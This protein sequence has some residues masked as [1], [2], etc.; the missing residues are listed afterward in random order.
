MS[1]VTVNRWE[2]GRT[3][4]SGLALERLQAL[5]ESVREVVPERSTLQ[6]DFLGNPRAVRLLVE[7]ERLS[8]GHLANPAFAIETSLVDPL[9]HQRIAVYEHMLPHER[10]RFLLADDAGAG[11]TIMAGLYIREMLSRRLV[12]R[13]LVVPPAGL[14]GNWAR[15]LQRFFG[16]E[17][18]LARSS[19]LRQGNPFTRNGSDLTVCSLDTLR[20]EAMFARLQAPDVEPYDLVVF[21]EAHKL[22]ARREPDLTT[23]KTDRYKLAEALAGI[24]HDDPRWSL[25]WG[26]RHLLLLTATPHMG[27]DYPYYALWRLLEPET[28]GAFEAFADYGASERRAHF[29]RRTKEEMVDISGA[30]LYRPRYS[31]TLGFDLSQGKDSEQELYDRTTAYMR[32]FY[33]KAGILNAS[34][35]RLAQSV[36]QRRL[37]SSTYAVVRSLERRGQ[38]LDELIAQVREGRLTEHQI[39]SALQNISDPFAGTADDDADEA[40]REAHEEIEDRLL[41]LLLS[42]SLQDL[43]LERREVSGLVTLGHGVLAAAQDSKFT[44]LRRVLLDE[45]YRDQ[46]FIVFTEHRDTL[47]W[48]R[49]QLEAL[50]FTDRIA[51]IHGGL[52]FRQREAE[53]ERFRLPSSQGGAQYLLATDAAG[54]GINLQF[55]WLMVNYDIPW[56]PARLEQRMGRIHRYGQKHDVFIFNLVATSTREGQVL[57]TLLHKLEDIRLAM[58]SDKVFDVIGHVLDGVSMLDFMAEALTAEGAV[59]AAERLGGLLTQ[60][61]VNALVVAR[62]SIYGA[63]GDVARE[64]PRLRAITE[65]EALLRLLPGYVRQFVLNA[66]EE[67]DLHVVGDPD[68]FFTLSPG[69]P[70]VAD[71]LWDALEHYPPEARGRLTVY[72]PPVTEPAVFLHPGEPLFE[73]LREIVLARCAEAATQGAVFEDPTATEASMVFAIDAAVL[74]RPAAAGR[75][76][77]TVESVLRLVRVTADGRVEQCALEHLLLLTPASHFPSEHAALALRAAELQVRALGFIE[78]KVLAASVGERR[79]A[80]LEALPERERALVRGFDFQAAELAAMR[81][82]L[83]ERVAEGQIAHKSQLERVK[84]RQRMLEQRKLLALESTR[85]EPDR[86][87]TGPARVLARALVVPTQSE[88][89]REA[90]DA[91]VERIAVELARAWDEVAGAVVKDVSTPPRARAAGLTDHPGFD[92]LAIYPDG[93]R[94]AIEVKGRAH[95]GEIDVSDNEW[96][97]ACNLR[98]SYWLYAAYDC[99]T[100][101]PRLVRVQD[102]FVSLLVKAR[103]GVVINESDVVAAAASGTASAVEP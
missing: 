87:I 22:S 7:A 75:G 102:P 57:A 29:I 44:E 58:G 34:A 42:T 103:G 36:F 71:P 4:P 45:R 52:D 94:R 82:R 62:Q 37:A 33:N 89:V 46:K 76:A 23:V 43:E 83:A 60:D 6:T 79:N 11:K 80:L 99:A 53:V 72:R 85:S 39:R 56:N 70:G 59:R 18:L 50:G 40:G 101:S 21:D 1:F 5:A 96:A 91:D 98:D 3:E 86:I 9:P 30:P 35:A 97:R 74:Q 63:G 32:G 41:R 14:I 48:L 12:R 67:L 81:R 64:L 73:R 25:D 92:L 88:E 38:R 2:N 24:Q 8:Y 100:A 54:E 61:Q 20:G 10:L 13:V 69:R 28:L 17:F 93:Q 19:D 15:E 51:G 78:E 68:G 47:E 27:K 84:A 55:C 31:T 49:Q 90:F 65:R 26:A 95:G 66:A 77:A 16:L